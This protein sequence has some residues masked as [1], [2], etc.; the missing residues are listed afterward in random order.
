MIGGGIFPRTALVLGPLLPAAR[1]TIVDRAPAHLESARAQIAAAGLAERVTFE[2]GTFDAKSP[3]T[4]DLLVLP[5]AFRGDRR[6]VYCRPP[7]RLAAI[8][9]WAWRTAGASRTARVSLL[10]KRINL[11]VDSSAPSRPGASSAPAP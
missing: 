4:C 11:V 2:V 10:P 3:L 6:R 5:L 8:H 7:A 1:I 9:D